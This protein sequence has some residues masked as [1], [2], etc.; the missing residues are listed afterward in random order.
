M[1]FNYLLKG[2]VIGFS[3]ALPVGPIALLCIRRTLAR[4]PA[5]GVASGM[6]AATADGVYGLIAG[7]GITFISNFLFSHHII[8]RLIGGCVL[9]YLGV[10]VFL[11][12]P[13]GSSNSGV[14]NGLVHDYVSAM[15]LTLTNP[16]TVVAF[17]A[18]FAAAGVGDSEGNY[19]GTTVLVGGVVLGSALWWLILCGTVG[20]LHRKVN[21]RVLIFVNRVSGTLIAGFG[22]IVLLSLTGWIARQ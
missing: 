19:L 6:G 21:D 3:L 5:S 15:L 1:L 2:L 14:E 7:F 13:G 10:K 17:A 9:C 18:I 16:M 11:T 20:W 22:L 4:G 8:M 12:V